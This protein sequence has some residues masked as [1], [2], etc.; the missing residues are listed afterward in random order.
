[1]AI[2]HN[3]K[4][5]SLNFIIIIITELRSGVVLPKKTGFVGVGATTWRQLTIAQYRVQ[6]AAVVFS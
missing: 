1:M 3:V 6:T 2:F 4:V 5:T